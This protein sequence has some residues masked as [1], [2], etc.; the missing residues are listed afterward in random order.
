MYITKCLA[1][2]YGVGTKKRIIV[3]ASTPFRRNLKRKIGAILVKVAYPLGI[4]LR[5]NT[6][7]NNFSVLEVEIYKHIKQKATIKADRAA[8]I[9][10]LTIYMMEYRYGKSW[11]SRIR[12]FLIM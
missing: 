10:M 1:N 4:P 5:R 9:L 12:P 11:F 3:A 2:Q 7:I 6:D 8:L